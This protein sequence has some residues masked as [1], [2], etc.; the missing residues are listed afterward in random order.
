[1]FGIAGCTGLMVTGFGI[2]DSVMDIPESQFI[3][4]FKYETSITLSNSNSLEQLKSYINSNECVNDYSEVC[5]TTGKLKGND[6]NYDVAIFVP[7]SIESFEKVCDLK[8]IDNNEKVNFNDTGVIISDKVAE[9]LDV[10]SGDEVT[11]I[12]SD[13][14][15]YVFK[16]NAIIENYV[17]HY[18]YMSKN[19]YE[20]NMKSYDTNMLLINLKE[21]TDDNAKA[22]LSEDVLNMDGV[23]SVSMIST[24][25]NAVENM[26]SSLNYVVIILIVASALLAFVVLYNLANINIGERQREIA[27]LKVLGFYDKEVDN[28]INK[29]NVIFTIIGV[30]IG[31][32]FGYFLTDMIVLSVEIDSLRFIRR[33]LPLSYVYSAVITIVFSLTVNYIIHFVLKKIDMIESL[34]SVE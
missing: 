30:L 8:N 34:K 2:K 14:L 5:A 11:L 17:G 21:A 23:A 20:A 28:Y 19:F 32:M 33:I 18:V 25:M 31:L 29:E 15:E 4:I 13:N 24:T 16:V 6:A 10:K 26:L 9:F 3:D 27:T 7:D 12:D 22:K 1:M